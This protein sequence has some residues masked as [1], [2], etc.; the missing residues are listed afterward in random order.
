VVDVMLE[1]VSLVLSELSM[2]R[3]VVE[4]G[5]V[6]NSKNSSMILPQQPD[7]R[8]QVKLSPQKDPTI[9]LSLTQDLLPP[10]RSLERPQGEQMKV[11]FKDLSDIPNRTLPAQPAEA[12]HCAGLRSSPRSKKAAHV[13]ITLGPGASAHQPGWSLWLM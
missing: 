10:P 12:R 9:I 5:K 1:L 8:K 3:C 7:R 2:G 4:G 6:G 11:N 13:G